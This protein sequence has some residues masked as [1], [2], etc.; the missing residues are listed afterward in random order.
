MAFKSDKN[1][2]H[3]ELEI[4][5][6]SYLSDVDFLIFCMLWNN[7]HPAPHTTNPDELQLRFTNRIKSLS[8]NIPLCSQVF[9][10]MIADIAIIQG[11]LSIEG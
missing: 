5:V 2:L 3:T 11:R 4:Y 8:N 7:P 6:E 1:I 10:G 9:Y